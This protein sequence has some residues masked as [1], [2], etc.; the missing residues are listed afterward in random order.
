MISLLFIH[1]YI[2]SVNINYIYNEGK[3]KLNENSFSD[4]KSIKSTRLTEVGIPDEAH[5]FTNCGSK[6]LGFLTS[7]QLNRRI[8]S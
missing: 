1:A 2:Q 4:R 7:K 5:S 3:V 8:Y 6:I